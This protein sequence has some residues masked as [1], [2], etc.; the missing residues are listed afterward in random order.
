VEDA[1]FEPA[2]CEPN[3]LS[4]SSGAVLAAHLSTWMGVWPKLLLQDDHLRTGA[5]ETRG[6]G[7]AKPEVRVKFQA[8]S[9]DSRARVSMAV[10]YLRLAV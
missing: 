9:P 10:W 2:R 3:P 1:G 6:L 7:P 4:K 8:A 5:N